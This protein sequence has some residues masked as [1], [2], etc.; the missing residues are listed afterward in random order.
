LRSDAQTAKE[1]VEAA[2]QLTR[3]L[4]QVLLQERAKCER[5][6]FDFLDQLN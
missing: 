3:A 4:R 5:S 1:S 2:K 6:L